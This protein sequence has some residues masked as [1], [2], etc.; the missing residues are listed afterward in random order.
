M[1]DL[2]LARD[3]RIDA[4]NRGELASVKMILTGFFPNSGSQEDISAFAD[5]GI[6]V[7]KYFTADS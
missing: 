5:E 4:A 6:T 7:F 2:I 1:Y 3:S